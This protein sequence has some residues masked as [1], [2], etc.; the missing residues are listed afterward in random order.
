MAGQAVDH[1]AIS[2]KMWDHSFNI[3]FLFILCNLDSI[4]GT[5]KVF[6]SEIHDEQQKFGWESTK[7]FISGRFLLPDIRPS[8]SN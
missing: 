8:E 5:K 7:N 2:G 3:I 6:F 1:S 4:K